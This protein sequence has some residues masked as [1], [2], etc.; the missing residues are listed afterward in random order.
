MQ[1]LEPIYRDS[2]GSS[3]K[4]EQTGFAFGRPA[5]DTLPEPLDNFIGRLISSVVRKLAPVV[6]DKRE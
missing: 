6:T 2:G 1:I 3:R 5:S 4:L